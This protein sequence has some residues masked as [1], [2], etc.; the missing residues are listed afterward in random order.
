MR[1]SIYLLVIVSLLP[2]LV[3]GKQ[4]KKHFSQLFAKQF[5]IF[6]ER[7]FIQSGNPIGV[8]LK[9]TAIDPKPLD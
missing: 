9:H 1:K 6:T 8:K 7:H 2:V 5:P 3:S 4:L